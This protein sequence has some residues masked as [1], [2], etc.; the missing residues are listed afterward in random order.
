MRPWL[1]KWK[2][3]RLNI[4]TRDASIAI[5]YWNKSTVSLPYSRTPRAIFS[6]PL[7]SARRQA[8]RFKQLELDSSLRA[9]ARTQQ[10]SLQPATLEIVETAFTFC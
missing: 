8:S 1:A 6:V 2:R 10:L 9:A 3:P 5:E 7:A 4:T